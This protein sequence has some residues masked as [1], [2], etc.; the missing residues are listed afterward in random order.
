MGEWK[1]SGLAFWVNGHVIHTLQGAGEELGEAGGW[2]VGMLL[3]SY[4]QRP[5][6]DKKPI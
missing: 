1:G 6:G 4:V 5:G 3:R 2:Q